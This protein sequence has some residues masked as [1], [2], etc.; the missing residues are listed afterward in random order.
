MSILD[1]MMG[2]SYPAV[3]VEEW[4]GH[5]GWPCWRVSLAVNATDYPTW[6]GVE[7][8]NVMAARGAA[9]VLAAA[10]GDCPIHEID[11]GG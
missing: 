4:S 11:R 7:H 5:D 10:N 1:A 2:S 6:D 9:R 8:P 3:L